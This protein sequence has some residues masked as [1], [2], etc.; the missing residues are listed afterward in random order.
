MHYP[1]EEH[2]NAN[3]YKFYQDFGHIVEVVSYIQGGWMGIE[4][5]LKLL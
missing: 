2:F 4:V 3:L 1:N 5:P